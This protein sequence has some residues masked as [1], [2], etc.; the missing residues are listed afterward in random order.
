[1]T[2]TSGTQPPFLPHPPPLPSS[3]LT[4]SFFNAIKL[5]W[6]TFS[7]YSTLLADKQAA[8]SSFCFCI[9]NL[10]WL[11]LAQSQLYHV[12]SSLIMYHAKIQ[13]LPLPPHC[14]QNH[15]NLFPLRVLFCLVFVI[16][17]SN[18]I[19]ILMMPQKRVSKTL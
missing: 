13:K 14:F 11:C 1:M 15:F 19:S 4:E 8:D 5:L 2:Q 12:N 16:T 3:K 10:A 17:C 9:T 18:F 6:R 7:K